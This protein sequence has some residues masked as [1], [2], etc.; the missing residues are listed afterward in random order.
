MNKVIGIVYITPPVRTCV[1]GSGMLISSISVA[2]VRDHSLSPV[3]VHLTDVED[4]VLV[5]C[6]FFPRVLD[7]VKFVWI[8]FAGKIIWEDAWT[9]RSCYGFGRKEGDR[10]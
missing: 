3:S 9:K 5:T 2:V 4:L 6:R 7:K 1:F 8:L 10:R